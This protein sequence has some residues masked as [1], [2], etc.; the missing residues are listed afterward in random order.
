MGPRA[1]AKLKGATPTSVTIEVTT[2][3]AE[4]AVK[5]VK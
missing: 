4:T 5:V 1:K 2:P 3:G